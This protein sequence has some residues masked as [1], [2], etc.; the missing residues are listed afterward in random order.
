M[1]SLLRLYLDLLPKASLLLVG[2]IFLNSAICQFPQFELGG[3]SRGVTDIGYLADE[4]SVSR[5]VDVES[6]ALFDIAIRGKL[7][8]KA[9]VYSEL[10]LGTNLALFD[11]SAS[12][13]QLRRIVVSGDIDDTWRYEIGDIDLSWTPYTIWNYGSEGNVRESELFAQWRAL[14]DYENFSESNDWRLKGAKFEGL[15][16]KGDSSVVKVSNFISRIKAS[17]EITRPEVLMGGVEIEFSRP[18]IGLGMRVQDFAVLGNTIPDG[19]NANVAALGA[20][21]SYSGSSLSIRGEA[22]GSFSSSVAEP[23]PPFSG[24]ANNIRGGFWNIQSSTSWS[25]KWRASLE[26]HSVSDTYI[27][28]ASQSKRIRFDQAPSSFAQVNNDNWSRNLSQGDILSSSYQPRG[29]RPWNQLV[30]RELMPYDAR[31]GTATPYGKATPNR[32]GISVS[33]ARGDNQDTWSFEMASSVLQD[34]TPEGVNNRRN[35]MCSDAMGQCTLSSLW[36]GERK[37]KVNGGWRIQ[38]VNRDGT[39]FEAVSLKSQ[40][41]DLGGTWEVMESLSL[42]YGV[43][44]IRAVGTEYLAQRD[45]DFS[46]TDFDQVALDLMDEFQ[47][48][49]LQ[50]NINKQTQATIQ[51]QHWALNDFSNEQSAMI[52]RVLFVFKTSF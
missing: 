23:S 1:I 45:A 13:A 35:Y 26:A 11:T 27:A 29:N 24:S 4:D 44:L 43:K 36:N 32:R 21:F 31:Y 22:G 6:H 14:Q 8:P 30:Q 39:I 38:H 19:L 50:W 2:L 52:S 10:R 51:W 9:E 47:A 34:L 46:I 17:D 7:S 15:W 40:L 42:L 37:L 16:T 41:L 33:I 3:Y 5:D 48:M 49:G 12:Y 25:E 18:K 28:P 20:D